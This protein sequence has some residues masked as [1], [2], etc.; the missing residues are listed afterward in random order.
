[1]AGHGTTGR[2]REFLGTDALSFLPVPRGRIGLAVITA[3]LFCFLIE[4]FL[5]GAGV[6]ALRYEPAPGRPS[7]VDGRR[8]CEVE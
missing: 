1:M 5:A 3:A 8:R 4:P 6:P 2:A 7:S